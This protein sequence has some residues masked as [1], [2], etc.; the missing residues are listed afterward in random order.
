MNEVKVLCIKDMPRHSWD[1]Q[2]LKS[3]YFLEGKEYKAEVGYTDKGTGGY[4]DYRIV[5][6]ENTP[7]AN[8]LFT[9]DIFSK[10]FKII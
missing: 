7:N 8:H 10:Y 4:Y 3:P 2:V 9:Q 1:R 5:G 6:H